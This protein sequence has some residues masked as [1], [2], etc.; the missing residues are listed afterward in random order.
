MSEK[1]GEKP[2]LFAPPKAFALKV[3]HLYS[4]LPRDGVAQVIG[5]QLLRSG[6]SV[7]A[8]YR[9]AIRAQITSRIRQQDRRWLIRN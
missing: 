3:I 4:A 9:E 8:H 7:G 2:E 5:K 6:T 1:D